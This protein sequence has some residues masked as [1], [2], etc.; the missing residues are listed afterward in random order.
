MSYEQAM[1]HWNNPRKL[2]KMRRGTYMGFDSSSAKE[3]PR[4]RAIWVLHGNIQRWFAE[5]HDGEDPQYA[6]EGIRAEIHNLR[7]LLIQGNS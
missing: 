7:Q 1:R 4:L 2:S 6:R 3:N 5:R